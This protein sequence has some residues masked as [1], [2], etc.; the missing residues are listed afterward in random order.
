MASQFQAKHSTTETLCSLK[1]PCEYFRL[2]LLYEP[3]HEIS[4][5]D[6]LI[7]VDRDEL[8]SLLLSLEIPNGVQSVA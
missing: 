7:S 3:R 2:L 5:F 1:T 6:I 8:S 4:N